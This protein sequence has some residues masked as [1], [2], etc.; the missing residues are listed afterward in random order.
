M[1]IAAPGNELEETRLA[2]AKR[3]PAAAPIVNTTCIDPLTDP[4]WDRLASAHPEFTFFH[5]SA[6][7]KVLHSTYGHEPVYHRFYRGDQLAAVLPMMEVRSP[8]KGRRGVCLPFTDS[9]APLYFGNPEPTQAVMDHLM[10]ISRERNWKYFEVRGKIDGL[11]GSVPSLSFYNHSLALPRGEDELQS[12]FASPVRRAIRKAEQNG[13]VAEIS[14]DLD[15]LLEFYRLHVLT[16]K[17]HGLPPQPISF[18][19][20]IHEHVIKARLGFVVL[21]RRESR[22]VAGA[23]FF[24]AGKKAIYKFGASDASQQELRGNNLTMWHGIKTLAQRGFETLDFGRTSLT[25]EGLRR[26]KLSWGTGESV[27]EYAKFDT[28]TQAWTTSQDNASGF[29][30][31]IFRAMPAPLN[32]LAGSLLYPHLD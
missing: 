1:T 15:A 20:N 22:P 3:A 21:T 11:P 13:L 7:A 24:H 16:R 5:S 14:T 26:F 19:R 17:R 31:T 32:R 8:F 23:V 9:C 30:N 28:A 25:N 12:G 29:H 10:K 6:W 2:P 27:V 18:F 4:A